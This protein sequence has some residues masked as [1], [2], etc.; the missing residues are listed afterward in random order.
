MTTRA[1]ELPLIYV[2]DDDEAFRD[3]LRW[4]LESAGFR[5]ATFATA[6]HFL[7]SYQAGS[8]ACLVLDVRL[9]GCSG[10]ELQEEIIRRGHAIPIIFVTGH[11]D[12]P[13]AVNAV[14]KG[15]V[16]FI[17]KPFN[18]AEFLG[19]VENAM[20]LDSLALQSRTRKVSAALRLATLTQREREVME[21]IVSGKQNKVIAD[22]LGISI[23][24]V[25]A[26]RAK[27]ME[28]VGVNS[29]AE[30]VQIVLD[31]KTPR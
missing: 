29:V 4:L 24:T 7:D 17:E 19:L 21:L 25:E 5:V 26:H 13:M 3:S 28:K 9:P 1:A 14:K 30:L 27:V 23:K 6:E 8:A 10:L 22:E 31:S 18:D 12:V 15:A 20:K 2:V 11:G 16:D